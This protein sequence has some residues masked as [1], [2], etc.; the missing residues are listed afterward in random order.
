MNHTRCMMHT[1]KSVLPI[2]VYLP[3]WKGDSVL[4]V[5]FSLRLRNPNLWG[6]SYTF[7]ER[8]GVKCENAAF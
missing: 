3:D 6:K 2:T 4:G 8:K 1:Y 7:F 5:P